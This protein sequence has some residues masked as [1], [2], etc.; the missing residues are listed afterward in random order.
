MQVPY[1]GI[2][3]LHA[4]IFFLN[5]RLC[6]I[7]LCVTQC[8]LGMAVYIRLREPPLQSGR[9]TRS[10][11]APVPAE[12]LQPSRTSGLVSVA[13]AGDEHFQGTE[14]PPTNETCVNGHD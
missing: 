3:T 10:F 14:K 11:N 4:A 6:V 7:R 9:F 13:K 1:S 12:I 2:N 5:Y 8:T